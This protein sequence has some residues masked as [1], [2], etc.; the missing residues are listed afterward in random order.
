MRYKLFMAMVVVGLLF[1][2]AANLAQAAIL[3][4]GGNSFTLKFDENGNGSI[5]WNFA[6]YVPLQG[7]LAPDPANGG[8][9]ALRYLLPE[10]VVAGDVR[11][12]E[13]Y[14]PFYPTDPPGKISDVLRF[15]NDAGI[16]E[17]TEGV[18]TTYATEMFYYSDI[19]DNDLA[20]TGIPANL[21]PNDLGGIWEC[22]LGGTPESYEPFRWSPGGANIYLGVSDVPEAA[23]IIIWF[24]LSS[25]FVMRVWRR[26]RIAVPATP[27]RRLHWSDESRM[28]I[29]QIIERGYRH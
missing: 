26:R 20:D 6:G 25:L 7:E 22:N 13:N 15:T 5:N 2:M 21:V 17:T 1:G 27:S 10:L 8:A 23:S 14:S 3:A 16:L 19:G 24:G 9:L 11:L 28:A 4:G 29:H 18:Q 12:W